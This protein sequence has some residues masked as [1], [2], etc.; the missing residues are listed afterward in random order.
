MDV[1]YLPSLRLVG[2][3]SVSAARPAE[4][5]HVQL[6]W[7]VDQAIPSEASISLRLVDA[8]GH[9]YGQS[10]ECPFN[11][12]FPMWQWTPGRIVRAEH[13]VLIRPGTP[14][15]SYQLEMVLVEHPGEKGCS[16]PPG[17]TI[18][19]ASA[20]V[21]VNRG[22]RVLLGT[23]EVGR[24]STPPS[25]GSLGIENPS[26][27]S[28]GSLALLGSAVEAT[29]LRPGERVDV[30]L[31]WQ[32]QE[33]SLPDLQFRLVLRQARGEV[34][35]ERVIRPAGDAFPT[36]L[37]RAQDCF[38][39]QFWL[40][41]PVDAPA[42]DYALDLVPVAPAR[43]SG[44][45]G[46]IERRLRQGSNRVHLDDFRAV[47]VEAGGSSAPIAP[48]AVPQ[49]LVIEHPMLATLGGQV[50][51]LGYDLSS[52]SFQVGQPVTVTLYWQALATMDV[53]YTVFTHLLG[54]A[55]E[56]LGQKDNQ[57]R[58][59]AYPTSRWQP[60]EVITDTYSF[61]VAPGTLPGSY[62][63]EVGMYRL[64]T[65][66]RLPVTGADGRRVPDDRILLGQV[67][68]VA[69]ATAAPTPRPAI[70]EMPNRVYLPLVVAFPQ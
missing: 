34:L 60:G 46:A 31:Y 27:A 11:G 40:Q 51:F 53:D 29:E 14:P 19:P 18:P 70:P 21:Q 16:G 37:W 3:Q 57:P 4:S 69:P 50:R 24:A 45:W 44:L 43:R 61:A 68:V 33:G 32:A 6:F 66:T 67:R 1:R 20:P 54:P 36:A 12:L 38:E 15:G 17:Q 62:P 22:D 39:G 23:I 28:F 64:E 59:G 52:L 55:D 10:D 49:G 30:R 65:R 35:A 47:A 25:R 42:G 63:L 9:L 41:V 26:R 13:E 2:F 56:V 48:V 5:L 8:E 58:S 7:A